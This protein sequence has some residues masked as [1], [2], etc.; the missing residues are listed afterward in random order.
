MFKKKN[1]KG[2]NSIGL[3][4][5]FQVIYLDYF[6]MWGLERIGQWVYCWALVACK[7]QSWAQTR[8]STLK[9]FFI[10]EA[11]LSCCPAS[12]INKCVH[13]VL[14]LGG[15][16]FVSCNKPEIVIRL[17]EPQG[18][19]SCTFSIWLDSSGQNNFSHAD[20]WR[21]GTVRGFDNHEKIAIFLV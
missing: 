1:K 5:S 18:M 7:Q 2:K 12:L 21:N 4:S 6:R 11:K 16:H 20:V 15:N 19:A 8:L 17:P 13:Y 9:T 10:V 14:Q 3:D